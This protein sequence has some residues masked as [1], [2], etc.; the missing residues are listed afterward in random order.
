MYHLYLSKNKIP[1]VP[2]KANKKLM[3]VTH[4]ALLKSPEIMLENQAITPEP[5]SLTY[6]FFKF[7]N[8]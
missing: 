2:K 1:P 4:V 3:Q 6:N 7:L 5:L 8:I